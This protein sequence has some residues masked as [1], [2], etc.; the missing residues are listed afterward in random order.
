ML[1]QN[2]NI[3]LVTF[4]TGISEI[5]PPKNSLSN[6]RNILRIL[7]EIKPS[8]KTKISS[9]LHILA[10]KLKR[11]G[12]VVLISDLWDDT[13]EI[14]SGI[15]HLR[16]EKHEVI[17]FHILDNDEINLPFKGPITFVDL[18]TGI[19][20]KTV[21]E[22]IQGK[23]KESVENLEKFFMKELGKNMIDYMM[24]STSTTFDRLLI[25]YL[26]KRRRLYR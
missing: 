2:D 19:S 9:T 7:E 26:G 10:E 5:I 24:V 14:I 1:K 8:E 20:L 13:D 3:G 23:Y 17:V 6:Y 15:K 16:H 25:K 18:E 4:D 11:R 22:N 12:L 21:A